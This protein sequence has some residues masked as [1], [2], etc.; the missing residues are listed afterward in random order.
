MIR[1]LVVESTL[2]AERATEHAQNRTA[3]GVAV[4]FRAVSVSVGKRADYPRY[5]RLSSVAD[6]RLRIRGTQREQVLD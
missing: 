1:R 2:G 5:A 6:G 3:S 4:R